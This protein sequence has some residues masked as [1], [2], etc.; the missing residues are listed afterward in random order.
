MTV[1]AHID[2][3]TTTG[4]RILRELETHK[5]VVRLEYPLPAQEDGSVQKTYSVQETFDNLYDKLEG[6]YGVDLRKL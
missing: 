1:I 6:H 3:N 2:I 4:R 5:R